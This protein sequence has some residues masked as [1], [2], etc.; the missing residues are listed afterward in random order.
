MLPES[1]L[2]QIKTF[3]NSEDRKELYTKLYTIKTLH[4]IYISSL[5]VIDK[6]SFIIFQVIDNEFPLL[7]L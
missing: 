2:L 4:K 1:K 5:G 3:N 6:K 7:S